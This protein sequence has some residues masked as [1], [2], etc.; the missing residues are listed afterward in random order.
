MSE[1]KEY[2]TPELVKFLDEITI[3]GDWERQVYVEK[4][5]T[6]IKD[7]LE[8]Q[9]QHEQNILNY[10][11]D[12]PEEKQVQV[13]KSDYELIRKYSFQLLNIKHPEKASIPL[14]NMLNEFRE[15]QLQPDNELISVC[16]R[17]KIKIEYVDCGGGQ[18]YPRE[19]CAKC[20]KEIIEVPIRPDDELVE[21]IIDIAWHWKHGMGLDYAKAEIRKLLK[22]EK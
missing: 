22:G 12:E 14:Q 5:L 1:T 9:Y 6:Q 13:S 20:R 18:G 11:T 3:L 15:H 17:A 16:C 19:I 10:G 21:K 4:M 8:Q 7:I 2:S